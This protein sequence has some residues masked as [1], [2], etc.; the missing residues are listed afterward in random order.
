M[1]FLFYLENQ[2]LKDSVQSLEKEIEQLKI[3]KASDEEK[4]ESYKTEIDKLTKRI[5]TDEK[6]YAA[7]RKEMESLLDEKLQKG[8][9][10][11]FYRLH[12]LIHN[13]LIFLINVYK[14]C[15]FFIY[16]HTYDFI[17]IICMCVCEIYQPLCRILV[18]CSIKD[19]LVRTK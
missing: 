7:S 14:V 17:L 13:Y 10:F 9:T 4:I 19:N 18:Y 8:I 6:E 12:F 5:E 15:I 2:L 16:F 3:R 1:D 11:P